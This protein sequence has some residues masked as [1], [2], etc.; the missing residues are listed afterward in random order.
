MTI[1]HEQEYQFRT[2][3]FDQFAHLQPASILDVFQDIAGVSAENTPGMGF[4]ELK[5]KGLFWALTRVK[6]EVVATPPLHARVIAK[7]WPLA[8]TR[9]GFQREY[10]IHDLEGN[11]LVK[12]TSDWIVMDFEKRSF[13][14]IKDIYDGPDDFSEERNFEKRI[15]KVHDFE[16]SGKAHRH[17]PGY[18]EIDVNGHVNNTKYANFVLDAIDL[19]ESDFIEQFQIDYRQEVRKGQPLEIFTK[20]EDKTIVAKGLNEEGTTCFMCQIML[21]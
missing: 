15:R 17:T 6:Y 5:G 16:P 7:T 21:A 4:E 13:V 18:A 1:Q 10:T 12:G 2:G 14:S 19:G 8:P 11:L 3:D 20:R 9:M